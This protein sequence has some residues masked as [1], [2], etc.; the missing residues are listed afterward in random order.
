MSRPEGF[1]DAQWHV[2]GVEDSGHGYSVVKG[3]HLE[4]M[5]CEWKV[6]AQT[7]SAAVRLYRS[8]EAERYA[9]ANAE[10]RA[11]RAAAT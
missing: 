9:R 8:H 6:V 2:E 7:K 3:W 1:T 10:S 11:R 5:W 4:C